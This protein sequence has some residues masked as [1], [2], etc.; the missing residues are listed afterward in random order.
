MM[1]YFNGLFALV[2]L[3][4]IG[5]ILQG[6]TPVMAQTPDGETPAEESVCDDLTGKA[7][8]L[9]NA[10][11]EAMDCESG[12]QQ[13]SDT[14]CDRVLDNFLAASG[15]AEPPCVGDS[16]IPCI[17]RAECGGRCFTGGGRFPGVCTSNPCACFNI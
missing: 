2:F 15:G 9:C 16:S 13:A 4:A 10:Y 6:P 1:K 14:A 12:D 17:E 5:W 3:V 8:G 7:W 11:C